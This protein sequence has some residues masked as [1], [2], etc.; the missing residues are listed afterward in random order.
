MDVLKAG[1]DDEAQI[2]ACHAIH[3]AA[4]AVD[5]PYIPPMS[6]PMFEVLTQRGWTGDPRETW[7]AAEEG[8]GEVG[9]GYLALE[10]PEHENTHLAMLELVVHPDHRRRGT[11]AALLSFA[12][13]RCDSI[14]RTT[15]STGAWIGSPGEQ[16]LRRY[17]KFGPG[18]TEVRRI[19]RVGESPS[20]TVPAGYS[21]VRW[22]GATPPER[23]GQSA[24]VQEMLNDAPRDAS[25]E[26][27]RWDADRVLRTDRRVAEM[28]LRYYS[29]AAVSAD[30]EMAA[31]TQLAVDPLLPDWGL[32]ELTAVARQHRG[33]ALGMTLKSEMLGWLPA[34]EPQIEQIV[35][36]NAE[37]NKHMIAINEALGFQVLGV[38]MRSWER[39]PA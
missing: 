27:E 23:V 24:R 7:L 20:V 1:P 14:H 38:P 3:L 5:D 21:L 6:Y 11:G 25:W 22:E 34:V 31:V 2:R 4:S 39:G 35:T 32:Q 33:H 16:F 37:Q 17:A 12:A 10:L 29:I 28:G 18:I 26:P 30:G 15:I 13:E 36:W 9:G 19:L 8:A